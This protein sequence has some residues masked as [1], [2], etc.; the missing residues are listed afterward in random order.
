MLPAKAGVFDLKAA[1]YSMLTLGLI[2]FWQGFVK[3][4]FKNYRKGNANAEINDRI[5]PRRNAL[6]GPAIAGA[7]W[8]CASVNAKGLDIRTLVRK[9]GAGLEAAARKTAIC[10]DLDVLSEFVASINSDRYGPRRL[11]RS[12]LNAMPRGKLR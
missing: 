3:N 10:R 8:D 5:C 7:S 2:Y 12:R 6:E 1:Q 9:I 4:S 11:T